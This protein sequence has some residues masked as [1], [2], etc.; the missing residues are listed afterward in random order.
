MSLP[1][2]LSIMDSEEIETLF[3]CE[4]PIEKLN[5]GYGYNGVLL[6]NK[7]TDTLQCHICG[8]WFAALNLH[9]DRKHKVTCVD[10]RDTYQLPFNF[11]LVSRAISRAHSD[12]ANRPA[13]L[14]I[15]AKHRDPLKARIFSPNGNKKRW[16]YIYHRLGN[17]NIVGA[18]P[19]QLR[20]R[21]LMVADIVGR[22]PSFRDILKHDVKMTK[23]IQNR[24]G[25]LNKFRKANGFHVIKS[26]RP[27]NGISDDECLS[28]LR[29]FHKRYGHIPTARDFRYAFPTTKTFIDHFGSWNRAIKMAGFVPREKTWR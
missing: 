9:V 24:Y 13:S 4:P 25:T 21:Y 7:V 11:P 15:L 20:R 26:N 10:Y 29:K 3:K 19:E 27:L 2:P 28:A 6:R 17:D 23:F 16:K 12:N 8:K 5:N 1:K 18:C 14:E 22:D